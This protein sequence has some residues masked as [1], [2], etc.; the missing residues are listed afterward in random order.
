MTLDTIFSV[1]RSMEEIQTLVLIV[2]SFKWF[3]NKHF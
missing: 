3:L 2:N 1:V